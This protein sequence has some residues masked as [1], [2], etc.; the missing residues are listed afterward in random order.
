MKR[1]Y[2]WEIHFVANGVVCECCGEVED[3]FIP[4]ACNAHTHGMDKFQHPDF[5]VVV[6]YAPE[7]LGYILNT[8]GE[9]VR[10]GEKF[11]DGQY[12][13]G[14]FEDC[15]IRLNEF[16]ENGRTVLR[17]IIPDK[18]GFFPECEECDPRYRV[19]LLKTEELYQKRR[20]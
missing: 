3:G 5:Q 4:Y 19:Q 2:D 18:D 10:A 6:C 11:Q 20:Q 17:V 8:F 1:K 16:E 7:V 12:V 15:P 9:R 14:I 13:S